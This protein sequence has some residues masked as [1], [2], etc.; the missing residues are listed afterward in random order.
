MLIWNEPFS[1]KRKGSR[2]VPF[3]CGNIAA[4][5]HTAKY[6]TAMRAANI[7]TKRNLSGGMKGG[8]ILGG[9]IRL[10]VCALLTS[11][12]WARNAHYTMVSQRQ[13]VL[14]ASTAICTCMSMCGGRQCAVCLCRC[15]EPVKFEGDSN[16]E[17][18]GRE[19]WRVTF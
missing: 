13:H 14:A 5:V 16:V 10:Y 2:K 12:D 6:A 19:G 4:T 18:Q 8:S 17:V 9:G 3:T 7:L 15:W 1:V 11:L